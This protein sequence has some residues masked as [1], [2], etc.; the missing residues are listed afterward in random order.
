MINEEK[1]KYAN[2]DSLDISAI[3]TEEK[4]HAIEYWCEGNEQLKELLL[5][6]HNNNVETIGCCAG[7][8]KSEEHDEE[9]AYISIAIKEKN[10]MLLNLL[11]R[12][13]EQN[14]DMNIGI[15]R[16]STGKRFCTLLANE[17]G[18]NENF[19][20]GINRQLEKE[21]TT[22]TTLKRKYQGLISILQDERA[23]QY[24]SDTQYCFSIGDKNIRTFGFF[25]YGNRWVNIPVESIG[26][27]EEILLSNPKQEIPTN[28]YDEG[29]KVITYPIEEL[30]ER[31]KS[32]LQPLDV[33]KSVVKTI[34]NTFFKAKDKS[35]EGEGR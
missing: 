3:S 20:E 29:I 22:N 4:I 18:N 10:D 25:K 6:C 9:F 33:I 17:V 35:K 14:I 28:F 32:S 21:K 19:F 30:K 11:A 27:M 8:S 13:E 5:Y 15:V 7:H 16:G 1:E 24:T 23:P 12:L 2:G 34:K 31:A 26:R